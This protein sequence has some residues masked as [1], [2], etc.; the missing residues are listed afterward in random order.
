V[1][2]T[3]AIG[4]HHPV[5]HP[6]PVNR[7]SPPVDRRGAAVPMPV[8]GQVDEAADDDVLHEQAERGLRDYTGQIAA[9]VGVEPAAA[10]CEWADAPSIYIAL[11]QKLPEHPGR[12]VALLWTAENGWAVTIE[13]GCGEDLLIVATLGGDVLPAPQTVISFVRA[14]LAGQQ[15]VTSEGTRATVNAELTRRLANWAARRPTVAGRT[16]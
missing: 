3:L 4:Q 16:G 9:A 15:T 1:T 5:T 14:V 8:I 10:W 11:D 13:T 12:D 2:T 7:P 6:V